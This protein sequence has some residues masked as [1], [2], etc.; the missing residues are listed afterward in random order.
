MKLQHHKISNTE[1]DF[2]LDNKKY[3]CKP[4][5]KIKPC[6][7]K[8]EFDQLESCKVCKKLF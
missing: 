4:K 2:T 3:K 7:P 6:F 5:T 8:D 1:L